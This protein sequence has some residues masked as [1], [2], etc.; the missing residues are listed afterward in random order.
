MILAATG[1]LLLTSG[2]TAAADGGDN[3]HA[4]VTGGD[5]LR[6]GELVDVR[7][8]DITGDEAEVSSPAFDH[9]VRLTGRPLEGIHGRVPIAMRTKPGS[10]PLTAS[11]GGRVVAKARLGVTEAQRPVFHVT[12]PDD[13]IRP[14]E[15]LGISFD[16]L[17]PGETGSS[18]SV[19][20]PAFPS[21]IR[22]THD[23]NG[24]DWNNPRLF[25]ALVT[26]PRTAKDGTYTVT[27]NGPHGRAIDQKPLKI[28]AARPGDNDYLGKVQ[29]PAFFG[30]SDSPE[31]ARAQRT[32]G[33]GGTVQVLWHDANPDPGEEDQLTATSPAF[34][35]PVRLKRDDSK[36]GDGDDPRYFA[37][38]RIR[39]DASQGS[40][41]VTVIS[42]HGRIKRTEHLQITAAPGGGDSSDSSGS[43]MLTT[44]AG[45]GAAAVAALGGAVLW[46]RRRTAG[47]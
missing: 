45:V 9:P 4:Q 44:T 38:A 37:P 29:G 41:P 7:V 1:A 11:V 39:R 6:P 47:K 19:T 13:V 40:Y 17:Y 3:T 32:V 36:A 18:F 26:V 14:G 12:T 20:S 28:A 22:L 8:E 25:E 24:S 35:H 10:Y 23:A 46:R 15:Q 16:D 27:L 31:Q 21:P 42:H 43:A 30:P 2:V 5:F 33:A 34:E